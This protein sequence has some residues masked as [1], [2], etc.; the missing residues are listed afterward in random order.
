MKRRAAK[1]L[2]H[3][4]GL[5]HFAG[6]GGAGMSGIA[7]I[8]HN[9][10]YRVQGSDMKDS[11]AIKRL[12]QTG[13]RV[14]IGHN[15]DNLA[16]ANLVV[17]SSA[18]R[19]DNPELVRARETGIPLVRRADML[20]ELMRFKTAIAI[21]GTHGKTTTTSLI[22]AVLEGAGLDPT[23]ING[24]LINAWGASARLGEGEWMV[25]EADESDGTF[26]RLPATIAVVTN[27]DREH[28]DH[29]GTFDQLQRA[30]YQFVEQIPFYGFAVMC[31]DHPRVLALAGRVEDRR[32]ITYGLDE[33][34]AVRGYNAR[35]ID[36]VMLF[37][38][39]ADIG[40]Q[41]PVLI[42]DIKLP[43]PGEHNM[44]NALAAI[45]LA[46]ALDI[47]P[48][49]IKT[50]LESFSGVKRRFSF[51]GEAGG[52]RIYDDYAHHPVEIAA[53]LKT[54]KLLQPERIIAVIQPHRYSRLRD[55]FD[56]FCACLMPADIVVIAP[57]YAAGEERGDSPG[58]DELAQAMI[59]TGHRA[60][61]KI[62]AEQ[63]LPP[64]LADL[65]KKGDCVLCMGA[66]SIT[67]WAQDLPAALASA[68]G[69][70]A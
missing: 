30:F 38:A 17:Y 53:V 14:H 51:A 24:G 9:L 64:L 61:H 18:L 58:R 13:I 65:G 1:K 2:S 31:A 36:G 28:M 63:D 69:E 33:S 52:I 32:I 12:R 37:D 70:A 57:V 43:L 20:G 25:V 5:V 35:F 34:A 6:I 46:L 66:G 40:G 62:D 47:P 7:E 27:I 60:V 54:A 67:Q 8:M 55:L 15:P 10:G 39:A 4:I 48:E 22:A 26:V 11:A 44:T 23:T 3:D 21:A 16:G 42:K 41:E 45:A 50:A 56:A 68:Q 49:I 29:Y 19:R 59:K